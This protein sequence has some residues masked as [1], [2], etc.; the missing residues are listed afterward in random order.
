MFLVQ[1][2]VAVLAYLIGSV[3]TATIVSKRLALPD[4]RTYGSGNPGA[5]NVLRSGRKDAAAWTLAGDALKGLL[6]VLIARCFTA[7]MNL[8]DGTVGLAAMAV[9]L[10]HVYPLFYGFKGGKGVAT[11]F[12]VILGMSWAAAFWVALIWGATAYKSKKSSLAAL[13]AAGCAPFVAFIVID[14]PSWGWSLVAVSFLVFHRHRENIRRMKEGSEPAVGT[15]AAS[16]KPQ[17]AEGNHAA[18]QQ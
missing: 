7:W 10:G 11:G 3:S 5:T 13:V 18:P 6:A 2:A 8:G 16:A 15:E 9:V 1:I 17:S 4:P 14:H 12:G